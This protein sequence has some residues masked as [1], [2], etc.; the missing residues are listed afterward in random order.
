MSNHAREESPWE[1]TQ[2]TYEGF[3]LYLR[4]PVGLDFDS[5]SSRFPVHFALTHELSFRRLDGAP[6]PSY[7]NG[8]ENF[9]A[10]VTGYFSACG[11]GQ[12]VLVETFGGKRQY[13]FYVVPAVEPEVVL[14][15]LRG[16]FPGFRLTGE[17]RN[18]P[19]WNFIRRYT[20]EHLGEA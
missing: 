20:K 6:E 7:N 11:Q 4:R 17:A 16:R 5:S 10:A 12:V 2:R 19:T 8:L 13:H 3:P 9:D 14:S 1:S 15:D 18:D